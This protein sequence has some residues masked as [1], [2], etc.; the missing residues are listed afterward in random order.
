MTTPSLRKPPAL[1]TAFEP[2]LAFSPANLAMVLDAL[3]ARAT[4]AATLALPDEEECREHD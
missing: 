2:V 4:T 3:L 1:P